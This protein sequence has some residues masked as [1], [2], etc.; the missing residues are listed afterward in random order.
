M[1]R[2]VFHLLRVFAALLAFALSAHAQSPGGDGL[3]ALARVLPEESRFDSAGGG[4]VEI[5]LALS[6]PVPFRVFAV[7]APW[8]L[9][10]D[11]RTV[12]WGPL[13]SE[14]AEDLPEGIV[15]RRV[16][17]A[18]GAEWSRMVLTLDRPL[19]PE[20]AAMRTDPETGAA[21]VVLRLVPV[22]AAAFAEAARPPRGDSAALV[23]TVPE[24]RAAEPAPSD[25]PLRVVLD[26]GHGGV[27]PGA[28][29]GDLTEAD[30]VLRFARELRDVLRRTGAVEVTLTRDGDVFVPLPVRV[31]RARAARAD[32]FISIHADALAEGRAQGATV[33]TLSDTASDA[34][35]AALAEQHDRADLVQGVD[36]SGTEDAVAGVLMD[37]AR[38]E[39]A[40]RARAFADT[41][42]AAIAASDA[43]LHPRPR[44]E[45]GFTV[46]KAA[47]IPSVLLEIG[48]ISDAADLENILDPVWRA[49]M[50][51]AV[52]AAILDWAREDAARAALRRQ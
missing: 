42:V 16:G 46:L 45:A 6:Q 1:I 35:T 11:L 33:Y 25:R 38:V 18:P 22:S 37:L 29:R 5:E 32:L 50:Q 44:G 4:A 30:L 10:L 52:A 20:V 41:L 2:A 34:A 36:L 24:G 40:P 15:A 43:A 14:A 19:V 9:V 3:S 31:S 49:D 51:A 13:A 28:V 27:D 12:T 47:D 21:R 26:P 39:T 48:Y 17:Q 8:R 23:A 7:T